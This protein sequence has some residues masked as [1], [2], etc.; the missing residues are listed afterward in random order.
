METK[1]KFSTTSHDFFHSLSRAIQNHLESDELIRKAKR[2]LWIKAA[3]YFCMHGAAYANLLLLKH[4]TPGLILSYTMVGIS[5]MLLAFNVSHDACHNTF[6][7]NQK[8]NRWLYLISFNMQGVSG[9]LWQIRHISSH[10]LFPNVDGCDADIDNNPILRLSP[11]HPLRSFQ[12]YQHLY[13]ILIYSIYSLHW[14]L[15]KD[16]VYMTKKRVANLVNTGHPLYQWVNLI[17]WKVGY[18]YLLIGVPMQLGYSLPQVLIAFGT[19]QVLNSWFFIHT[20]IITHLCMETQFP[21]P[22]KQGYL[23]TDFHAHQ[24]STSLDFYPESKLWNWLVG[25][26]NAHAAHHLF[27]QYPHTIYPIIAPLI[28]K[29]ALQFNLP[30]NKLTFI[31]GIKSHYRYLRKMGSDL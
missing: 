12:K 15:V 16:W 27:P 11:Q 5:G 21:K 3:L 9:Y 7:T 17:L 25:G 29:Q 13:A 30:Y 10:H 18:L 24:L 6:S 14:L 22:D 8:L 19:M 31:E 28:E 23:P 2:L 20:L 26:F 4:N 1:I